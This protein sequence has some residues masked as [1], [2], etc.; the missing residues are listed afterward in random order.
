MDDNLKSQHVGEA[1]I[2]ASRNGRLDEVCALLK[3]EEFD[4]VKAIDDSLSFALYFAS[5]AGHSCV[6]RE[7]LKHKNGEC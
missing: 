5:C 6:V 3:N 1:F 2:D 7:L 4:V